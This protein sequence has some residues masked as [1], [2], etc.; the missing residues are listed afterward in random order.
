MPKCTL[1]KQDGKRCGS[2]AM[3]GSQFCY[4]HNPTI[5]QEVK[6]AAS[7]RGGVS[8]RSRVDTPLGEFSLSQLAMF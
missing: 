7:S 6:R 4:R 8:N 3:K 2:N 1:I 5:P